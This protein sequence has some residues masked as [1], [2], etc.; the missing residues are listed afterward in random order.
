MFDRLITALS[1]LVLREFP[2]TA[3]LGH[4]EY[5]I[6]E[7]DGDG[8]LDAS[9]TDTT[10]GLPAITKLK[11][12]PGLLGETVKP[13]AGKLCIVFFVNGDRGRPEVSSCEGTNDESAFD[14]DAID[15][16]EGTFGCARQNDPILA[17][18]MFAGTITMGSTKVK[19][20]G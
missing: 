15:I 17:G 10:I 12:R 3:F 18:G 11:M 9:P 8:L 14:A 20:G 19:V 13:K 6:Q 5:A 7:V 16:G 1:S 4:Y 2:N